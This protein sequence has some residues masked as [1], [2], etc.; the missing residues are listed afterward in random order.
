MNVEAAP[1]PAASQNLAFPSTNVIW[2]HLELHIY[3]HHLRMDFCPSECTAAQQ[4]ERSLESVEVNV[5][6]GRRT[7][8]GACLAGQAVFCCKTD[9][10]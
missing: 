9:Q 5:L 4:M 1:I 7:R 3:S 6:D 10:G 8:I 2:H